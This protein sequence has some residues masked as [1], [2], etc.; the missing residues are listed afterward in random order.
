M[1]AFSREISSVREATLPWQKV[2]CLKHAYKFHTR[3]LSGSHVIG[4]LNVYAALCRTVLAAHSKTIEII[5]AQRCLK[6][7]TRELTG[8]P[9]VTSLNY[10]RCIV[11]DCFTSVRPLATA[12]GFFTWPFSAQCAA[13]SAETRSVVCVLVITAPLRPCPSLPT[14]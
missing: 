1:L 6:T 11:R 2:V 7:P 14:I 13:Q 8:A 12:R 4:M 9:V 3:E 5:S 10:I